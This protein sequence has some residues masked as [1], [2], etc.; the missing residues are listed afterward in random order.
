MRF[1]LRHLLMLFPAY[2]L[3]IFVAGLYEWSLTADHPMYESDAGGTRSVL[4][5]IEGNDSSSLRP[6]VSEETL[7]RWLSGGLTRRELH[8]T[9]LGSF[10]DSLDIWGNPYRAVRDLTLPDGTVVELGVYSMGEDGSSAS[11]GNDPDDINTWSES[12]KEHYRQSQRSRQ[13]AGLGIFGLILLPFVYLVVFLLPE[14]LISLW[15][16]YVRG[17]G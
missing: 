10:C 7:N 13:T 1:S 16:E 12:W 5:M 6:P 11:D 2:V 9:G 17:Y 14:K 15:I 8:E 3:S 4:M